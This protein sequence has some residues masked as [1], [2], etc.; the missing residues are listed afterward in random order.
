M[1]DRFIELM[2]EAETTVIKLLKERISLD[3]TEWLGIYA[4][5]LL[6]NNVNILPCKVG[7]T[8]YKICPKCNPNHNGSCKHCAWCGCFM[9]GCDIGVKVYSDGSHSNYELQIVPYKVKE[10]SFITIIKY[11]NIMFFSNAEEAEK[12]KN[13]YNQIRNIEDRKTR[14]EKYLSWEAQRKQHYPFLKGGAERCTM[15]N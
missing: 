3:V 13:E 10:N 8:V 11:W 12:A 14:Y 7:E 4:D 2:K 1:R 15:T 9:N 6:K 5:H